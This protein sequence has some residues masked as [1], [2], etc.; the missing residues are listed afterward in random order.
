MLT[1]L[2]ASRT[3]S[4][5]SADR[6]GSGA[7]CT[8]G[9]KNIESRYTPCVTLRS[10]TSNPSPLTPPPPHPNLNP[11]PNPNPICRVGGGGVRQKKDAP[12]EDE[13]HPL[14]VAEKVAPQEESGPRKLPK[15]EAGLECWL[16]W[17]FA[18]G[19]ERAC[20]YI[21]NTRHSC[22]Q[23]A[24]KGGG[25]KSP[26]KWWLLQFGRQ[27]K[28]RVHQPSARQEPFHH[29]FLERESVYVNCSVVIWACA[30]SR[31]KD[32]TKLGAKMQR[33][34]ERFELFFVSSSQTCT[35]GI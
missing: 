7:V 11:N 34:R 16:G 23:G 12:V 24:E 19:G 27:S 31:T 32:E 13:L 35:Q 29:F 5:L 25:A 1:F 33:K 30:L 14:L 22:K 20:V 15:Q 26:L 18:G 10:V 9:N 2:R 3:F 8:A 6:R 28:G 21:Y 4:S 17:A